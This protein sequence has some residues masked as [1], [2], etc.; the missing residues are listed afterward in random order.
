MVINYTIGISDVVKR[1]YQEGTVEEV[2]INCA[3]GTKIMVHYVL[4][5]YVTVMLQ[6]CYVTVT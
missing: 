1:Q 2:Q 4:Q 3:N 6:L 5:Y